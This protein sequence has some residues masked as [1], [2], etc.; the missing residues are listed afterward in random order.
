ML[1]SSCFVLLWIHPVYHIISANLR[2]SACRDISRLAWLSHFY[3]HLFPC[4]T[5][6]IILQVTACGHNG[7]GNYNCDKTKTKYMQMLLLTTE[8]FWH[9]LCLSIKTRLS[10]FSI[11]LKIVWSRLGLNQCMPVVQDL[12]RSLRQL[13]CYRRVLSLVIHF[14]DKQTCF[15][16]HVRFSTKVRMGVNPT[17]QFCSNHQ[18][19][20]LRVLSKHVFATHKMI[21]IDSKFN[22]LCDCG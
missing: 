18:N 19:T 3:Q 21:R 8:M 17:W 7:S 16:F 12:F 10:K 20:F 1:L 14:G 22:L 5:K 9:I 6:E 15:W 2:S 13:S 11:I 4:K